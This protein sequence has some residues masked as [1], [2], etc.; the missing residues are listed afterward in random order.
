MKKKVKDEQKR[1][2]Q[3]KLLEEKQK[4]IIAA[5]DWNKMLDFIVNRLMLTSQSTPGIGEFQLINC[6]LNTMKP[7]YLSGTFLFDGMYDGGP[8]KDTY[9]KI[10]EIINGMDNDILNMSVNCSSAINRFAR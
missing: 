5:I 6:M 2:E 10:K 8:R 9:Y 7:E 1:L 4:K 3:E